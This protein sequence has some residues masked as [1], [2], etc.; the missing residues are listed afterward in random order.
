MITCPQGDQMARSSKI[1]EADIADRSPARFNIDIFV[2]RWPIERLLPRAN[3][4]RTHTAAQVAQVDASIREFGWTNPILVGGD[5]DVIA[6]HARL[7]AARKLGMKEVPVSR[8]RMWRSGWRRWSRPRN[9]RSSRYETE[10][11][12]RSS[13]KATHQ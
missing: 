5:D 8:S 6:G 13:R 2:E 9:C 10:P 7:L 1:A 12:T 11:K 4:P 3:N